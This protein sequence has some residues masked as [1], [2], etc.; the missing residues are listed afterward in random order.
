MRW[1]YIAAGGLEGR[2]GSHLLIPCR[3]LVRKLGKKVQACLLEVFA[4]PRRLLEGAGYVAVHLDA[5]LPSRLV[6]DLVLEHIVVAGID[7]LLQRLHL[8][9]GHALEA[10]HGCRHVH[11]HL[12]GLTL[13]Q[14]APECA[15]A[16]EVPHRLVQHVVHAIVL[17]AGVSFL[18]LRH[19]YLREE[20]LDLLWC[21]LRRRDPQ[22]S[23]AVPLEGPVAFVEL[24]YVL[25]PLEVVLLE[26][27]REL[28]F[29][30]RPRAGVQL[31]RWVERL[32]LLPLAVSLAVFGIA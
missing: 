1:R 2:H 20:A 12:L 29:V 17:R 31:G 26:P 23:F 15:L 16:E 14:S 13:C 21:A 10:R 30:E 4:K 28:G 25:Y 19:A 7:R 11:P 32:V 27:R 6:G 3:K 9:L 22:R 24:A 8:V 18:L 5:L